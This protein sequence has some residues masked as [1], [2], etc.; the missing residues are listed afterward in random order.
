MLKRVIERAS[1]AGRAEKRNTEQLKKFCIFSYYSI[2]NQVNSFTEPNHLNLKST[3]LLALA[4]L[5]LTP[6]DRH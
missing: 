6:A 3:R 4:T 1:G 5:I 2:L